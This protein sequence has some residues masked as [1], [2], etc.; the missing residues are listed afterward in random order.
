MRAKGESVRSERG[1]R[2]AALSL[3]LAAACGPSDAAGRPAVEG[4][5]AGVLSASATPPWSTVDSL[6][7][8]A[9][10]G[11]RVRLVYPV[12]PHGRSRRIESIAPGCG[13]TRVT[14]EAGAEV[15]ATQ[16]ETKYVDPSGAVASLATMD[17][18]SLTEPRVVGHVDTSGMPQQKRGSIRVTLVG[19]ELVTLAWELEV[20][21]FYIADPPRFEVQ[22][23]VWGDDIDFAFSVRPGPSTAWRLVDA[24]SDAQGLQLDTLTGVGKA[25]R[26][27]GR[28]EGKAIRQSPTS[29]TIECR[30][31]AGRTFPLVIAVATRS[32]F[33]VEPGTFRLRPTVTP[34]A[35]VSERFVVRPTSGARVVG[36]DISRH[37]GMEA[38]ATPQVEL[39]EEDGAFVVAVEIPPPLRPPI[40]EVSIELRTTHEFEP[41]VGLRLLAPVRR[42]P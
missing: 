37:S 5:V 25:W 15:Y 10:E 17:L 18:T 36:A 28:W 8:R 39:K 16:S 29:A 1:G 9:L 11:E 38:G 26:I 40:V 33:D 3:L 19:G 2:A 12:A 42:S 31:E 27:Q 13:C 34:D 32:A 23:H 20:S 21:P 24:R 14:I 6:S 30:T 22:D 41:S 4:A 35:Q 7:L